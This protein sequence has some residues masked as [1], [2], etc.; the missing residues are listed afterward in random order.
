MNTIKIRDWRPLR[1]NRLL[2]FCKAEFA[3]GLII[4]DITVLTS[5][6]GPWASPPSKPMVDRNGVVLKDEAG[7]I[8][9][10]PFIEFTSKEIRNRWS[11]AVIQAMRAAHPEV[12][13]DEPR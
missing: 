11:S 10:S 9:Y 12:F 1:K 8:R 6:R 5:E 2:G 13:D 7:K 3:S 4:G